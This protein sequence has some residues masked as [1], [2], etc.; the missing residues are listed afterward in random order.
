MRLYCST[1]FIFAA[2]YASNALA[3]PCV[4]TRGKEP[5]IVNC[6]PPGCCSG[7][8]IVLWYDGK[9]GDFE[10]LEKYQSQWEAQNVTR[11]LEVREAL[12]AKAAFSPP[13]RA[14]VPRC[15]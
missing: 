13:D 3:Q 9:T 8:W 10:G 6:A 12:W 1:V 7:T 4:D 14:S 15:K 2:L 11:Q 5:R